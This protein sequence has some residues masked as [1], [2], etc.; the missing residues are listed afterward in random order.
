MFLGTLMLNQKWKRKC[1]L[2][3]YIS[4]LKGFLFMVDLFLYFRCFFLRWWTVFHGLSTL[5]SNHRRDAL[6]VPGTVLSPPWTPINPFFWPRWETRSHFWQCVSGTDARLSNASWRF[7]FGDA[8]GRLRSTGAHPPAVFGTA[9][10]RSCR[11]NKPESEQEGSVG[12]GSFMSGFSNLLG[13]ML[14][15]CV[16]NN[17][18]NK[19]MVNIMYFHNKKCI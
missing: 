18:S 5:G 16:N 14:N 13:V 2:N 15:I 9:S 12:A 4:F 17:M 1:S 19:I 11:R 10:A 3:I 7:P 8:D 6:C